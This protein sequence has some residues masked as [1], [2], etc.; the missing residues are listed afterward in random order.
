MKSAAAGARSGGTSFEMFCALLN[1]VANS[2]PATAQV[3]TG[4]IELIALRHGYSGRSM[5][6]QS[7]VGLNMAVVINGLNQDYLGRPFGPM[8]VLMAKADVLDKL[9]AIRMVCGG[10]ASR[11][12]RLVDGKPA[13][14][15]DPV[16][17]VG[18]SEM[19]EARCHAHH[20]VPTS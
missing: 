12:Q 4:S 10:T 16:I 5:L 9:H 15:H 7:L 11:S 3:Y 13:H 1:V 2:C 17:I 18:A 8:P 19:Y 20:E 14:Y 6:A